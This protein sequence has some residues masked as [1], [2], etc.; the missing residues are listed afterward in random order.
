MQFDLF[1]SPCG[2]G[3]DALHG[4][5]PQSVNVG[6]RTADTAVAKG[7][8]LAIAGQSTLTREPLRGLKRV[9]QAMANRCQ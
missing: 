2:D 5:E 1:G 9:L 4:L 7:E 8:R 3:V 6:S